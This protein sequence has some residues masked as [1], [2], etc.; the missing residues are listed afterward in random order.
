MP[1]GIQVYMN[2]LYSL[3]T[4]NREAAVEYARRWA[5]ARNPQYYDFENIGGDCTNFASQCLYAGCGVMNFRPV[6]GW[7]YLSLNNRA[8]A[9]TGVQYFYDFFTGNTGV[10]P[11]GT[12]SQMADL[13][14]GDFVQLYRGGTYTH[15][16]LV[17]GKI[18]G[19]L[20]VASHTS[21]SFNRPLATYDAQGMRFLHVEA[22]RLILPQIR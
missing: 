9:W 21:D 6:Y 5:F 8:P 3:I 19:Q 16:L 1:N 4:Y 2:Q 7:Y 20:L 18:R 17:T 22:A 10:G 14:K 15:T 12:E 11:F 13:E